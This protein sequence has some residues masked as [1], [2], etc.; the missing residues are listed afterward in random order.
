M[1]I[2][3]K[4]NLFLIDKDYE[5]WGLEEEELLGTIAAAVLLFLPLAF[6]FTPFVFALSPFVWFGLLVAAKNYKSKNNVRGRI[7]RK[8]L[9][10]LEKL[11]KRNTY[12][13]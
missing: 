6:L 11:M 10:K 1:K 2:N 4:E 12:Y 13:A 3:E 9:V 8:F 7:K 5:I